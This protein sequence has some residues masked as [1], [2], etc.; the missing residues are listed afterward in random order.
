MAKFEIKM[1]KLGVKVAKLKVKVAK[2]GVKVSQSR[3]NW[4]IWGPNG[5]NGG[6]K[7]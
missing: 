7:V 5:Q 6:Q 1:A 3:P 2:L 4:L